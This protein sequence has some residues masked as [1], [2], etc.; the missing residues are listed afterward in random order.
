MNEIKVSIFKRSGR[1]FYEM[2][3]R[4]PETGQKVRKSSEQTTQRAAEREA[5]KWEKEIIENGNHGRDGRIL[6]ADFRERYESEVL[7]GLA[8]KTD[9]KAWGVLNVFERL[10]KVKRLC[11]ITSDT[12]SRYQQ[13]LREAGRSESTIKSHLAHLRAA[14]SWAVGVKL[15]REVPAMPNVQRAKSSKMMKG[16]P[17]TGEEFERM[18][19]KV[20]DVVGEAAAESW[21]FLLRGLWWSGLRLAESL[22]LHWSDDSKLCVDLSL[23]HPMLRIPAELEKGNKDRMLPMAPEF[24]QFLEAVPDLQRGGY[25]FAPKAQRRPGRLGEQRVGRI[26]SEIGHRA[27]VVVSPQRGIAATD[28]RPASAD[29]KPAKYASAHDLRRSFGERWASRVMPQV[30]R[31][32]MRHESI[33]T[34]MRYYVGRN[35]QSTAAVLWEVVKD[36]S[37]VRSAE[38]LEHAVVEQRETA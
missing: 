16:R 27:G 34:T 18:L 31:E 17:I 15:L 2:Q 4:D 19:A 23:R 25:V 1:R 6:W 21:R 29:F 7:P 36:C 13:K 5:A 32:L 28:D 10:M 35:A 22:E 37:S 9:K 20:P 38:T 26:I 30:L 14:L 11:N 33:E 12:L 24:A 3:Y 8:D